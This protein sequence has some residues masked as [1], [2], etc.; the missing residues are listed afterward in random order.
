MRENTYRFVILFRIMDNPFLPRSRTNT[1]CPVMDTSGI[2][3]RIMRPMH[4]TIWD[5]VRYVIGIF[6]VFTGYIA[7]LDHLC[8]LRGA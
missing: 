4:L 2:F 1:E 3:E 5:E 7:L 8:S 6:E